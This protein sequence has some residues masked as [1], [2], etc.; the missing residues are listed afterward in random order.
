MQ[1]SAQPVLSLVL[2]PLLFMPPGLMRRY[3]SHPF[4][5]HLQANEPAPED[6]EDYEEEDDEGEEDEGEEEEE[7]EGEEDE[8]RAEQ[9]Q[10]ADM[11]DPQRGCMG[12]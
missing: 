6:E 5:C 10:R 11:L 4:C 9:S 1:L 8:V 7:D 12:M 2:V 3:A